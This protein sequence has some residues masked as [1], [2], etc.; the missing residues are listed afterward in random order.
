LVLSRDKTEKKK[1]NW[2]EFDAYG[3]SVQVPVER[4]QALKEGTRSYGN[5]R[6]ILEGGTVVEVNPCLLDVRARIEK[7][8]TG[9]K[10]C[11]PGKR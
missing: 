7:A 9:E 4:V 1:M 10:E 11:F 6:I 2:L 3:G 8:L 5:T